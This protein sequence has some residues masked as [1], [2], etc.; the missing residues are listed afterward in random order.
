MCKD[1]VREFVNFMVKFIPRE[2]KI[3]S[4]SVVKNTF[5]KPMILDDDE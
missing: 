2:T 4:T 3:V 1:S 5:E